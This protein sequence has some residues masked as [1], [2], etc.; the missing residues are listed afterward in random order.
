MHAYSRGSLIPASASAGSH[1][2]SHPKQKHFEL[3]IPWH[4]CFLTDGVA[5]RWPLGIIMRI[6]VKLAPD[7][8]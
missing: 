4:L 8:Y 3:L 1:P 2:S 6:K 7:W 5:I